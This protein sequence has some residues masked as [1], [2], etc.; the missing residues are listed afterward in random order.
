MVACDNENGCPY[1]WVS[2]VVLSCLDVAHRSS[3]VPLEL[4]RFEAARP[5]EMVLRRVSKEWRRRPNG[6][7][8]RA[9][10]VI[11]CSIAMGLYLS[12]TFVAIHSV[13]WN[14]CYIL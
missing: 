10:E 4:R 14:L 9:K 12:S 11:F 6:Y 1:E 2:E 3:I 8:E 5:G 7:S 13:Y